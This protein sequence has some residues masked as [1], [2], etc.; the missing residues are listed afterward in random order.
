MSGDEALL[1]KSLKTSGDSLVMLYDFS[2]TSGLK[3]N[4]Y[5]TI[6]LLD[7][8]TSK[9]VTLKNAL[10]ARLTF[11]GIQV[12]MSFKTY[13]EFSIK[14]PIKMRKLSNDVCSGFNLAYVIGGGNVTCRKAGISMSFARA[15][16]GLLIGASKATLNIFPFVF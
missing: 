3:P 1:V 16:A 5:L 2:Q 12:D 10:P 9:T 14:S 6:E 11:H 7:T 13:T 15:G 8:T 4:T